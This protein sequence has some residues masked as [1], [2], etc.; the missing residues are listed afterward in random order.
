MDRKKEN[1][2][3]RYRT[4]ESIICTTLRNK[5]V[6][7][8][9]RSRERVGVVSFCFAVIRP[10]QD[11]IRAALAVEGVK[12]MAFGFDFQGAQVIVNDPFIDGD[13]RAGFR[14]TFVPI[15]PLQFVNSF[16][17]RPARTN[18]RVKAFL[19]A[20]GH[21][22]RLRPLTDTMP[23]CM[24]PIRGRSHARHLASDLR[25]RWHQ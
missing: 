20:A 22:T 13:E 1:L 11:S 3:V 24:V 14:W 19:L 16:R 6:H 17:R 9:A 21:G 8:V 5:M 4:S 12:E 18:Q 25:A 23:K 7:W 10:H 15:S 2:E